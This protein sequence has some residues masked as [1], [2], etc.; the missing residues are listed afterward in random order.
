MPGQPDP[1]G[2]A[3]S[4]T[5]GFGSVTSGHSSATAP[6]PGW[7]NPR[8]KNDGLL[9]NLFRM[10]GRVARASASLHIRRSG[11]G[12]RVAVESRPT[13][14]SLSPI[15]DHVAARFTPRTTIARR[16][17]PR[18][19]LREPT[20]IDS[21]VTTVAADAAEDPDSTVHIELNFNAF[22]DNVPPTQHARRA[23]S[24]S[25][26]SVQDFA[27]QALE[28]AA[29]RAELNRLTRDYDALLYT[30]QLRDARLQRLQ[31]ELAATRARL[32]DATRESAPRPMREETGHGGVTVEAPRKPQASEALAAAELSVTVDLPPPRAEVADA[33]RA[34]Q[35]SKA[36]LEAA[37]RLIPLDHDG[38]AVALRRDIITIGRT[39]E[40]DICIPSRAVSRDHARLLMS[41]R[42]VTIVDMD[43][44]NG[45]FVNDAPVKK[46][47]LQEGDVLR[48]GD[49]SYR[50][51]TGPA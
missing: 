37:R 4:D 24:Y 5:L 9:P 22:A 28:L 39:K 27:D 36:P 11:Y 12:G 6:A 15:E 8:L 3:S 51:T 26:P 46:Q 23:P 45:C 35:L 21:H 25:D 38:E 49:R 44:A 30:L 42:S 2:G 10:R 31:H 41:P 40:N 32:R 19:S 48:I 20:A 43:S 47:K 1:G 7:A 50:F 18:S 33:T 14:L 17:T 16:L 34:T 13:T 29:L